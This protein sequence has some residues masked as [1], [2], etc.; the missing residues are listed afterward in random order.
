MSKLVDY[1]EQMTK[2]LTELSGLQAKTDRTADDEARV[3]AILLEA[4]DLGP[5][6]DRETEIEAQTKN[7]PNYTEPNGKRV[8]GHVLNDGRGQHRN[9]RE[10]HIFDG[11]SVAQIV[12][13]S[14]ELKT[15]LHNPR[16]QSQPID[17]GSLYPKHRSE[18]IIQHHA[19][20][21]PEEL[22]T[23]I[24]G[25]A[26]NAD[27]VSPQILREIYRPNEPVAGFRDVLLNGTT[28]S[29]AII[30]MRELLFTNAAVEVA[31]AIDTTSGTKPESALTFEQATA[32][33]QTV[34]HWIPITRQTLED[35]SQLQTYVQDRLVDGLNRRING[36]LLNGNGTPPNLQGILGTSNVQN[37]TSAG[38]FTTSPVNDAGEA[39]EN[40][41]RIRR[42]KT[43][44]R[45]TGGASPNFVVL[46]PADLEQFETLTNGF[47]QYL[48]GNPASGSSIPTLWGLRVVEDE[49]IADNTALVGDG[50]FAAVWDR[51]S[52]SI[53]ITDSHSDFFIKNIFVILAEARLALTVFRPQAFAKVALVA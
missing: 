25:G 3:D 33:V 26:L 1:R 16:G 2:I 23:L 35:A 44:V 20:M 8:S 48:M 36:E 21:G 41:N 22:R 24:Y 34:A 9:E 46:N 30:F 19:D 45:I 29:D 40:L 38:E 52:A 47:Q 10:P 13:E 17:V 42:A 27:M 39:N 4:N 37:L 5:K 14:D 53:Y 18:Q 31:E 15:Y 28:T 12:T 32:P 6:I 49:N 51:G 50:R 7:L 11:R 43:K